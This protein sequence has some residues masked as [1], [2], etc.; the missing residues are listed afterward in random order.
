M[1]RSIQIMKYKAQF[2]LT[3]EKI[4][5]YDLS[6]RTLYILLLFLRKWNNKSIYLCLVV[7]C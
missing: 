5:L 2:K 1:I 3:K 7:H 4:H 6:T